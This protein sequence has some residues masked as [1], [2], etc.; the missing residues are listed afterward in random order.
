[1]LAI[2]MILCSAFCVAEHS[3]SGNLGENYGSIDNGDTP[4][5]TAAFNG[6][7]ELVKELLTARADSRATNKKMVTP[8]HYAASSGHLPTVKALIPVSNLNAQDNNGATAL[9]VAY[10]FG[11]NAVTLEL[12]NNDAKTDLASYSGITPQQIADFNALR[13]LE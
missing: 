1:M 11:H 9:L 13:E 4:L 3:G 5:H 10:I 6:Q 7:D 8:L 12:I 2:S